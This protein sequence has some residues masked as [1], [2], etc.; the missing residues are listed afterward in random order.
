MDTNQSG[1]V[2]Q[3]VTV[4]PER[5]EDWKGTICSENVQADWLSRQVD[6]GR[7]EW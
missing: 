2:Y 6:W 5:Q 3:K 1:D 7:M 4:G